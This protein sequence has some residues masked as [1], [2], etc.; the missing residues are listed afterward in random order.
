[1]S[2]DTDIPDLSSWVPSIDEIHSRMLETFRKRPCL[3]QAHVCEAIL[4]GDWDIISIAG[5]GMG[6][7]LTF[8]MPLL[9]RPLGILLVI[10]P[11]NILGK[12]N[13]ETLEKAGIE[14]IFI[15]ARTAMEENFWVSNA[16]IFARLSFYSCK[17]CFRQLQPIAIVLSLQIPKNSC[18]RKVDSKNWWKT[19]YLSILLS[20]SSSTKPIA[21][22]SG[23]LFVPSIDILASFAIFPANI[24]HTSSRL[25]QCH[26]LSLLTS[27]KSWTWTKK[28]YFFPVALLIAPTLLSS[29]ARLH[30]P[31][32]VFLIS[33][34]SCTIGS[35]AM[36][37]LRN[38][39]CF[40]TIF[41]QLSMQRSFY[42]V[43]YPKNIDIVSSGFFRTCLMNSKK[44][45]QIDWWRVKR[46]G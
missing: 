46:G 33:S 39:L 27:K 6:K 42:A 14:G 23:V 36:F 31:L 41:K 19:S 2:L 32:A 38:F 25:L 16:L 4:N 13:V 30:I 45:K 20:E 28:S 9:F 43:Y 1:M 34:F 24:A 3:W 15:S 35:L 37:R 7:T 40:S 11:L 10:T 8:W 17:L 18:A 44:L 5:T 12:Q 29:F 21:S 26:Q 22:L